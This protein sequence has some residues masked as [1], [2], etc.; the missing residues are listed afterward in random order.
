[1]ANQRKNDPR[2]RPIASKIPVALYDQLQDFKEKVAKGEVTD[3]LIVMRA[4]EFYL[5]EAPRFG[6]DNKNRVTLPPSTK[7]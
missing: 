6:V 5:S 3:S 2:I 4:L 1:M 7:R